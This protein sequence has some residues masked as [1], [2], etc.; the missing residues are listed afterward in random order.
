MSKT[1]K[2]SKKQLVDLAQVARVAK[3][4]DIGQI[5]ALAFSAQTQP[6][7]P[8]GMLSVQN[9]VSTGYRRDEDDGSLVILAKFGLTASSDDATV[10]HPAIELSL[11]LELQYE[12]SD[13]GK[14]QEDDL[15]AFAQVNGPYNAWPY[16][17]E[18]VQ[19]AVT[20]MGLPSLVVPVFRVEDYLAAGS[21]EEETDDA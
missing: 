20:R 19:N 3:K 21:D 12:C 13:V 9:S 8:P 5:R 10:E 4:V 18:Y 15:E 1:A 16:W 6:D 11:T 7:M 2:T 14:F 17:R